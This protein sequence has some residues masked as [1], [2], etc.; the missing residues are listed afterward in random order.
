ME[1]LAHNTQLDC[2][3]QEMYIIS[4]HLKT[5]VTFIEDEIRFLKNTLNKY[6]IY[7]ANTQLNRIIYFKRI[8]EQQETGIPLIKNK[9]SGFLKCLGTLVNDSEKEISLDILEKF[10]TLNTEVKSIADQI[11]SVKHSFFLFLEEIT[12]TRKPHYTSMSFK[13]PLPLKFQL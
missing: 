13:K 1:L 6:N 8:I 11:L 9:I 3:L 7:I 5:D 10:N 2:E 4:N 12:K